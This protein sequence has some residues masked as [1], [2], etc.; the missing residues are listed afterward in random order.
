MTNSISIKGLSKR[1]KKYWWVHDAEENIIYV[2][3]LKE[4]II[5]EWCGINI[6]NK[7]FGLCSVLYC[8]QVSFVRLHTTLTMPS[9]ICPSSILSSPQPFSAPTLYSALITNSSFHLASLFLSCI[10]S[11]LS[12]QP[13]STK[14]RTNSKTMH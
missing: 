8:Q 13:T 11:S 4:E 9:I 10:L 3:K 7:T 12:L 1:T 5:S 14:A 2:D 6:N